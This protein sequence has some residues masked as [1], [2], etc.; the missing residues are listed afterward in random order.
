MI[1]YKHTCPNGKVYIGQTK[2]KP[3]RRWQH[4]NGYKENDYFYRAIKKYGWNNIKHEIL[5]DDLA[6]EEANELEIQLI[7]QYKANDRSCGYNRH[8]GGEVHDTISIYDL[9]ECE[10]L[11]Y[12]T[13]KSNKTLN[14][15][16]EN[17]IS[18][19]L[20]FEVK[21]KITRTFYDNGENVKCEEIETVRKIKPSHFAICLLMDKYGN[22]DRVKPLMK[23]LQ[24][25]RNEIDL[26]LGE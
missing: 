26:D 11:P 5:A 23:D 25:L 12:E 3:E 1:I 10:F 8:S 4:G 6:T 9:L 16:F 14:A 22:T 20:G 15:V 18:S 2:Q 13:I 19:A 21:E 24:K 17:L 7:S